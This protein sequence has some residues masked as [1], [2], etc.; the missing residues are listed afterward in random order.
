MFK[1][2]RAWWHRFRE[3]RRYHGTGRVCPVCEQPSKRF[4]EFGDPPRDEAQCV[5]CGALEHHRLLWLYLER[6]TELFSV[7]PERM[8]H[9]APEICLEPKLKS[10]L[11]DA[12]LT[13]DLMNPQAMVRM[14][15]SDIPYDEESFDVV[16]CSHVLEHV[17]DDRRAMRELNRVL[18]KDGWAILL[19]QITAEETYEDPS[20]VEP[21]A[22]REAFGQEDHCRR[23]GPDY[24]NRLR[25]AGFNVETLTVA[26][27]V[28]EAEAQTLG[29]TSA[30]GEIYFCTKA[31][32]DE[33]A[34]REFRLVFP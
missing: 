8:L 30:A 18:K 32:I 2:L 10:R 15:V 20:I 1:G 16:Y 14:D 17:Q 31:E 9:V 28:D 7:S 3:A 11:G 25:E 34:A 12:Y 13:A 27:L 5:H 26:D 21:E 29:L 6:K 23:Y 22:R 24:V 33:T 19:V 4:R